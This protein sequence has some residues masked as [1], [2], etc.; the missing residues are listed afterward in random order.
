[1]SAPPLI[2]VITTTPGVNPVPDTVTDAPL[3]AWVG[4]S[5]I[6]GTVIVNDAVA[7]S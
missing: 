1:M 7:L 5:V 4:F 6:A 3:G 2:V